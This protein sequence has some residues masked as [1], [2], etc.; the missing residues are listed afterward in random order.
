MSTHTY[1][2]RNPN[3]FD[4]DCRKCGGKHRDSQHGAT[5]EIREDRVTLKAALLDLGRADYENVRQDIIARLGYDQFRDLQ[6]AIFSEIGTIQF[7]K[8]EVTP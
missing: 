8:S 1:E 3:A 4:S 6:N 7:E 5:D 2:N